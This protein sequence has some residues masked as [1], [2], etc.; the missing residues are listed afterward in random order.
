MIINGNSLIDKAP[1]ENM[2]TYKSKS[3]GASFGLSEL[4]YDIRLAE[5]IIFHPGITPRF[6]LS[7]AMEKFQM[8][9][10]LAGNVK[11][12]S[13][14]ARQGLSLFNTIIAPSW[15]GYLTLELVFHGNETLI[16]PAG[17]GIAQVIF[18]PVSDNAKYVGKYQDQR[19]GPVEAILA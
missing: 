2:L 17:A 9:D 12:K 7:A 5:D 8:P 6:Q 15:R 3:G 1:I 4:G 19:S 10:D 16:I 13:T 14:W 18:H 11:D